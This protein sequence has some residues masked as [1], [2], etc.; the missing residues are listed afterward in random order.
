MEKNKKGVPYLKEIMRVPPENEEEINRLVSNVRA[1]RRVN[2]LKSELNKENCS[3]NIQHDEHGIGNRVNERGYQS[4]KEP[5]YDV[6]KLM[7]NI[8]NRYYM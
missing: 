7:E 1:Q 6:N 8:T 3:K 5:E 4:H 2:E